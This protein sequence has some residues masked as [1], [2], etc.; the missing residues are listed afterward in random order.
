MIHPS[1]YAVQQAVISNSHYKIV[2]TESN[3]SSVWNCVDTIINLTTGEKQTKT[4]KE[5]F[6]IFERYQWEEITHTDSR[7]VR[8]WEK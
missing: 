4:R 1:G 7:F 6:Q 2:M 8:S 3:D 5:W